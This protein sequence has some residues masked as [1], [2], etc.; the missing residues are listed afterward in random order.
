MAAAARK[1]V[2]STKTDRLRPEASVNTAIAP[3]VSQPARTPPVHK[4]QC[5]VNSFPD[6][7]L[8]HPTECDV[9]LK[10]MSPD[11]S[12]QC[13]LDRFNGDQGTINVIS[14]APGSRRVADVRY[15]QG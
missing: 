10:L 14:W 2:F 12:D 4:W 7:T 15:P 9:I 5:P 6:G 13:G 11:G 8:G 3:W 1:I